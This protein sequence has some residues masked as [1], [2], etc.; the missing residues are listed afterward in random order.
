MEFPNVPKIFVYY[1]IFISLIGIIITV[2]DKWAS[3]HKTNSRIKEKNLLFV[4]LLGGGLSMF[5][6][7]LLIRHKTKHLQFM[8]GIPVMIALQTL[9]FYSIFYKL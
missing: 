4:A 3:K 1:F 7:M 5:I 2:Y 6:T 8:I 9:A